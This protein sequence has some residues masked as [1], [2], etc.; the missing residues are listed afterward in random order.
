MNYVL[1]SLVLITQD[2][3]HS[4]S[5]EPGGGGG[6]A[7]GEDPILTA[8]QQLSAEPLQHLRVFFSAPPVKK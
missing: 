5:W 2:G 6:G 7:G 8:Q 1:E 4:P 3:M